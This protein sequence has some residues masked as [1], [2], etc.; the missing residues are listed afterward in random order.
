ML[1]KI[2]PTCPVCG[3]DKIWLD[4]ELEQSCNLCGQRF[5]ADSTC[6]NGHYVCHGCRRQEARRQIMQHCLQSRE[7]DLYTLV[8]E[9]M[10]LP[11]VWM[12]GPEHHL[13]LPAAML[14]AYQNQTNR[15]QLQAALEEADSRSLE[16]PGGACGNWGVCGA[17]IGAGIF[18]SI[19]TETT[20]YSGPQWQTTGQLAAQ[21]ATAI[22]LQG[23]PRCCKR[24]TFLAMLAAIPYCNEHL[25][26]HFALPRQIT[27]IFFAN[28]EDCKR[29]ACG[30]FPAS[31][32]PRV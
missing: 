13:L 18:A 16:V 5:E 12:H 3:Q 32:S 26:A 14:T 15:L 7:T 11:G 19:L 21:C 22:S 10:Q 29:L 25:G 6:G 9:L 30:F 24:D 31:Q 17:S 2:I 27:C 20:P 28:N 8:L 4:E 23:G 1:H